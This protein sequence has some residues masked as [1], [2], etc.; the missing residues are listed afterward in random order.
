M[1]HRP[2]F[3]VMLAVGLLSAAVILT[4]AGADEQPPDKELADITGLYSCE[5]NDAQGRGYMGRTVI[6]KVGDTYHVRWVV[7]STTY[8]GAGIRRG[9]ILSVGWA[10]E[11]GTGLTVFQIEKGEKGP[12]LVGQWT[13]NPPA[14][15]LSEETLIFVQRN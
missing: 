11:N 13:G 5:G 6:R 14:G 10:G 15:K 12:K 2:G 9:N 4:R 8:G 1:Y 7:G 3:I